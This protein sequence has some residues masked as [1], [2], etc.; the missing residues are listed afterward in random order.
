MKVLFFTNMYPD[1]DDK[2]AGLFVKNQLESLNR[3]GIDVD[4]LLV[5]V[6]NPLKDYFL[7]YLQLLKT[8]KGKEYD[9]IH[10]HYGFVGFLSAFQKQIPFILTL[11]GSDVN[12]WWQRIFSKFATFFA[13]K[14]I[15]TNQKHKEI[16]VGNAILVPTGVDNYT[17]YPMDPKVARN[18][19]G[20]K[21][22]A[23]YIVFPSSR[24]RKVKNYPLFKK[25]IM[26]LQEI[27]SSYVELH[28]E[29]KTP[30]EVNLCF[31][32]ADLLLLTSF[33]EGSPLVIREALL[34]NLPV[35]SL[36]VGDVRER[37][38]DFT[39]C[40]VVDNSLDDI[41]SK[42]LNVTQ[43]SGVRAQSKK[44]INFSTLE[45]NADQIISVY[46]SVLKT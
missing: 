40:Y 20:L 33:S 23:K 22:G 30:E 34:C 35:V 12:I 7:G 27:D 8:L 46:K 13:K 43:V 2:V 18:K 14:V 44:K 4:Y 41:V 26:K 31:N 1:E 25:V 45:S 16:M 38:I 21:D 28:L 32:A 37:I 29:D 5:N 6:K 19:L 10:A 39:N 15:V 36:D 42:I 24:K 17:F 3:K 9:L 11:H